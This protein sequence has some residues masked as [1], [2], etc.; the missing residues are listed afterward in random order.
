MTQ[1]NEW[2]HLPAPLRYYGAKWALAEWIIGSFPPPES[3][4]CYGEY[5]GG[6]GAIL[7]RKQ[8]SKVEVYNDRDSI[9]VNFYRVVRDPAL[10]DQLMAAIELTPFARAECDANIKPDL[11][12]D[13]P[14][15][16]ARK[17]YIC[18]WQGRGLKAASSRERS[19]WRF[20]R[21][22]F[23]RY[24][25]TEFYDRAEALLWVTERLKNVEIECGDAMECLDRYDAET[26]LHYLDPP[27]SH[28]T[29]S[30]GSSGRST[31]RSAT[32]VYQGEMNESQHE[33]LLL[34]VTT[35]N[36]KG[37]VVISGYDSALYRKY[38]GTPDS[39]KD[40]WS[41]EVR[42]ALTDRGQK[43][44]EYLWFNPAATQ[45]K[46]K[47]K[48]KGDS[49]QMIAVNP[50]GAAAGVLGAPTKTRKV[51]AVDENQSSMF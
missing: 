35:G 38:F 10:R 37:M 40:G 13:G 46:S 26:T 29:S 51:K 30:I 12:L 20:V 49:S 47:A 4:H 25:P 48:S 6:S 17:F 44:E 8:P 19:G 11:T 9:A 41:I 43:K 33:A 23:S 45:S 28:N 14:V 34:K 3:Y 22:A 27:Y 36:I 50:N 42:V 31:S 21:D 15:E 18:S 7:L 32:K 16:A 5:F 39:P 2:S 24:P 1:L